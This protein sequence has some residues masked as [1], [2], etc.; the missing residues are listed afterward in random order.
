MYLN[1]DSP[2]HDDII[3]LHNKLLVVS[4]GESGHHIPQLPALDSCTWYMYCAIRLWAM[5]FLV[6]KCTMYPILWLMWGWIWITWALTWYP[7]D[8]LGWNSVCKVCN[9]LSCNY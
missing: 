5:A 7:L 9:V 6:L 2:L 3:V 8:I 1:N 4:V